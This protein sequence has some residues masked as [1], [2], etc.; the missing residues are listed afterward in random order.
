MEREGKR[1]EREDTGWKVGGRRE[2]EQREI[3]TRDGKGERK[4][5]MV[6]TK[7][8]MNLRDELTFMKFNTMLCCH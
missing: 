4:R 8:G 2:D 5:T 1:T 6:K 3:N 7:E